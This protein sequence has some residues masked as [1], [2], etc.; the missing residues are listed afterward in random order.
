M[1][2]HFL[3]ETP[4][5]RSEGT[6]HFPEILKVHEAL[7]VEVF[8]QIREL[9]EA[10]IEIERSDQEGTDARGDGWQTIGPE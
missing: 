6:F 5:G 8:H 3:A 2:E 4:E 1:L 9:P 10:S 7:A